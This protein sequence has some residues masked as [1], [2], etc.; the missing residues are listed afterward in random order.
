MKLLLRRRLGREDESGLVRGDLRSD[1]GGNGDDD[2]G[3]KGDDFDVRD[4]DLDLC[5]PLVEECRRS[6]L[7]GLGGGDVISSS[8]FFCSPGTLNASPQSANIS[9]ASFS[10]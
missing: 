4:L 1:D 8:C 3:E 10:D 6:F 9:N 7:D 5:A 2:P